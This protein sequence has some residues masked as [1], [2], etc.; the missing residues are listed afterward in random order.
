MFLCIESCRCCAQTKTNEELVA[1]NANCGAQAQAMHMRHLEEAKALRSRVSELEGIVNSVNMYLEQQNDLLEPQQQVSVLDKY[2]DVADPDYIYQGSA[3]VRRSSFMMEFDDYQDFARRNSMTSNTAG[4][5]ASMVGNRKSSLR[6]MEASGLPPR[7][8][9][10]TTTSTSSG[11]AAAAGA[12]GASLVADSTDIFDYPLVE[13]I[14]DDGSEEKNGLGG[15]QQ[16]GF[17]EDSD[18]NVLSSTLAISAATDDSATSSPFKHAMR[19]TND[20]SPAA[21]TAAA[22]AAALDRDHAGLAGAL[23]AEEALAAVAEAENEEEEETDEDFSDSSEQF[24]RLLQGMNL[25]TASMEH[26]YAEERI[27]RDYS[28]RQL[29]AGMEQVERQTASIEQLMDRQEF[30][31]QI[32]ANLQDSLTFA[33]EKETKM[34]EQR[35]AAEQ[36]YKRLKEQHLLIMKSEHKSQTLANTLEQQYLDMKVQFEKIKLENKHRAEE[37]S[38]MSLSNLR[39]AQRINELAEEVSVLQSQLQLSDQEMG[40]LRVERDEAM[41]RL[42]FKPAHSLTSTSPHNKY[43]PSAALSSSGASYSTGS[44]AGALTSRVGDANPSTPATAAASAAALS[45]TNRTYRSPLS[46]MT[47]AADGGSSTNSSNN[48]GAKNKMSS[49]T[50]RHGSVSGDNYNSF[51][52]SAAAFASPTSG[53]PPGSNTYAAGMV[54]GDGVI[55]AYR[56]FNDSRAT[57]STSGRGS[58]NSG[59]SN[60]SGPHA[61]LTYRPLMRSSNGADLHLRSTDSPSSNYHSSSGAGAG[62]YS[63]LQRP[64]STTSAAPTPTRPATSKYDYKNDL[65]M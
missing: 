10:H 59:G 29:F 39:Q 61:S 1:E 42:K 9:N 60:G 5:G 24:K 51:T 63:S 65:R 22:A 45:S 44:A 8:P 55:S 32:S 33:K 50:P 11:A 17:Y 12:P 54:S 48:S 56:S 2:E 41:Q 19:N 15:Q 43:S 6:S 13:S 4:A 27:Y 14:D 36:E 40:V 38:D 26:S 58:S 34:E 47:P 21:A 18:G 35:A 3:Y 49:S 28:L 64:G 62:A 20:T 30:L 53:A 37:N 57:L 23:A 46:L 16:V 7:Q 52:G 25:I 31:E